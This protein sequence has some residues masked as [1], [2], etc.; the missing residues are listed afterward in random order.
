LRAGP[1]GWT[2]RLWAPWA[3]Q[4]AALLSLYFVWATRQYTREP[5]AALRR[6]RAQLEPLR[7]RGAANIVGLGLVVLAVAWLQAP[8]REAAIVAL[9]ALSLWRT[10]PPIRRANGFPAHPS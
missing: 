9:G 7:V 10:P 5:L 4:V 3:L 2:F 1:F 6:D 8:W